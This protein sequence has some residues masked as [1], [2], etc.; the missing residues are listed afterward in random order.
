MASLNESVA[1]I[2]S[3]A[4]AGTRSRMTTDPPRWP[5]LAPAGERRRAYFGVRTEAPSNAPRFVSNSGSAIG[6][7]QKPVR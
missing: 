2:G 6:F 5:G 3:P 1:R 7:A 4:C